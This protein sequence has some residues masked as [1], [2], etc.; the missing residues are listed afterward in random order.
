MNSVLEMKAFC[1]QIALA[2]SLGPSHLVPILNMQKNYIL[3]RRINII[4]FCL[5]K[6]FKFYNAHSVSVHGESCSC[7]ELLYDEVSLPTHCMYRDIFYFQ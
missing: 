5:Y 6:P 7:I 3:Y 4:R 1:R 2:L